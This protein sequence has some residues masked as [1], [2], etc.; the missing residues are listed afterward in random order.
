MKRVGSIWRPPPLSAQPHPGY[1]TRFSGG[2][3]HNANGSGPGI[4]RLRCRSRRER[5]EITV[6]PSTPTLIARLMIKFYAF[7]NEGVNATPRSGVYTGQPAFAEASL[8]P[9]VLG[10][11]AV[12]CVENLE[13]ALINVIAPH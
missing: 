13:D 6:P 8:Q 7:L 5:V 4:E 3:T 2:V 1:G 11:E 12:D 9:T 10:G